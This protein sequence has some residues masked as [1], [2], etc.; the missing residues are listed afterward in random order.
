MLSLRGVKKT[1]GGVEVLKG[2]DAVIDS[3]SRVA[4]MGP[5]GAGKTTLLR[6]IAG[7]ERP[8]AGEI[9]CGG[10]LCANGR[11]WVPPWRRSVG[12]VFQ[13]LALWPHMTV[14]E[15]LEFVICGARKDTNRKP[16]AVL[17]KDLLLEIQ[18]DGLE[19]RMPAQLSGGQQQRLA[20]A[21]ALAADPAIL[22]MDEAFTHLDEKLEAEL[23]RYIIDYQFTK[24]ITLL[25]VTHSSEQAFSYADRVLRLVNGVVADL[26]MNGKELANYPDEDNRSIHT[27]GITET[28]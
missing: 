1:I 26:D 15:H 20:I 22:L 11:T 7:L 18:L 2:V 17:V 3:A 12:L 23:W 4:L 8:D 16:V 14:R 19:D 6:L 25:F 5:S 27:P 13:D 24:K 21:R 9:S 28:V 10:V